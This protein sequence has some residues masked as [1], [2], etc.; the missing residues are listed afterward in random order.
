MFIGDFGLFFSS[1]NCLINIQC[2]HCS[3]TMIPAVLVLFV[4]LPC[5]ILTWFISYQFCALQPRCCP[6]I[7]DFC[8]SFY[9]SIC[10]SSIQ[11]SSCCL[12]FPSCPW[13]A[14]KS[15]Y[16]PSLRQLSCLQILGQPFFSSSKPLCPDVFLP[17]GVRDLLTG[18]EDLLID[19][20]GS[21]APLP[22]HTPSTC[23]YPAPVRAPKLEPQWP[24]IP[25]PWCHRSAIPTSLTVLTCVPAPSG[26]HSVSQLLFASPQR[27]VQ[28]T[29]RRDA[30]TGMQECRQSH[31][32]P[33]CRNSHFP[34]H[35]PRAPS[36]LQ[37]NQNF[38]HP[39]PPWLFMHMFHLCLF[40]ALG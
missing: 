11:T 12:Q 35:T 22:P 39:W 37:A 21:S 34:L 9:Q 2:K 15:L 1:I 25:H 20:D 36:T 29:G 33:L 17:E 16:A 24:P 19:G 13:W 14:F 6:P 26:Q 18:S 5:W 28:L 32:F 23:S 30:P 3:A 27:S 38:A 4:V 40:S 10:N 31:F 7:A 8:N